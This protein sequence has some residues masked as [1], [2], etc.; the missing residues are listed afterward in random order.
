[1]KVFNA[2]AKV[3]N[4]MKWSIF[5]PFFVILG[6]QV[7]MNLN[8]DQT[9]DVFKPAEVNFQVNNE[10]GN[11]SFVK[12][13]LAYLEDNGKVQDVTNNQELI[14]DALF[15]RTAD[16]VITIP[17]GYSESLANGEEMLL[18][19]QFIEGTYAQHQAE[20]IIN[21]FLN[22][23]KTYQQMMPEMT[24]KEIAEKIKSEL[25]ADTKVELFNQSAAS[26][27]LPRLS[28]SMNM[29]GYALMTAIIGAVIYVMRPFQEQMLRRRNLCAPIRES[30]FKLKLYLCNLLMAVF[31][32]FVMLIIEVLLF[33]KTMGSEVG[34]YLIINAIVFSL[35]AVSI[36]ML[37][38]SVCKSL[39]ISSFANTAISLG[40]AF[41]SGAFVPQDL[42]SDSV[43]L[44][45]SFQPMYW[46]VNNS[47]TICSASEI[48][49]SVQK[50]VFLG[51]FIM[52]AF[53]AAIFSVSLF[54]GKEKEKSE[55][56]KLSLA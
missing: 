14:P 32:T 24:E 11:T 3:F 42:L 4:K 20:H 47:N 22:T 40:T 16:Y 49:G 50:E 6:I 54:L 33:K 37:I 46:F 52:L 27:E 17:K 43:K 55:G 45:A 10:D 9:T 5:I 21:Q 2:Y 38:N 41:I 7:S 29:F 1:M 12:E 28:N 18:E 26:D 34:L 44:A 51:Y 25:K 30:S 31:I 19:S 53:A 15:F 13:F 48:S 36:G 56:T 23:Y 8:T 35:C 39:Q